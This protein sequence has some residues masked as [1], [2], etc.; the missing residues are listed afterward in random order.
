MHIR[1]GTDPVIRLR[2]WEESGFLP[3]HDIEINTCISKFSPTKTTFIRFSCIEILCQQLLEVP[4]EKKI[5]DENIST[6]SCSYMAWIVFS[7]RRF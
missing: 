6:N 5:Y 4:D 7:T 2:F 3:V 1:V